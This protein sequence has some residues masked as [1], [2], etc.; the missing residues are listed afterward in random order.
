IMVNL[1][2]NVFHLS[3]PIGLTSKVSGFPISPCIHIASVSCIF[4]VNQTEAAVNCCFF[5]FAY[6]ICVFRHF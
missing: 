5:S 1:L 4:L 6:I 3:V 2:I